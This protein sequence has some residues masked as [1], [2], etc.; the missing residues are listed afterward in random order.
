MKL[1]SLFIAFAASAVIIACK[2]E[3]TKRGADYEKF[4]TEMNFTG[5]K[6][7]NF[8]A[9]TQKYDAE[10]KAVRESMGEHPDRVTLFT[11]FEEIQKKQDAEVQQV[12]TADEFA[13]YNEFVA[14]NTRKRSRYNDE[15]LA[16]IQ[17]EAG[18]DEN[19]MQ[20]V[21]AANNAFEKAFSDAHDVYHGN[22]ELARE[23]WGKFDAQRKAAIQ[24]ALTPEQYVKFE[25]TVKDVGYKGRE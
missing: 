8:V 23:Y 3:N 21:N 12:L 4:K 13:K 9:I 11:K 7:T 1:K 10:R 19:Q 25:E 20:V 16:K 15:L 24:K 2:G 18:L 6:A 22:T 14:K 17:T 5:E